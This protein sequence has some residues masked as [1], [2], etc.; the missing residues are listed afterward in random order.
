[1]QFRDGAGTVVAEVRFVRG[2]DGTY[3]VDGLTECM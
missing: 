3:F 2:R 1:V